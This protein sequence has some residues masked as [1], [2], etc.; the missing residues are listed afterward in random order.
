MKKDVSYGKNSLRIPAS[1]S[2]LNCVNERALVVDATL[3]PT[4]PHFN[5]VIGSPSA[6]NIVD[7]WVGDVP[8]WKQCSL[9]DNQ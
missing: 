3:A 7:I 2:Y 8:V 6:H 5:P 4:S 9:R 1:V